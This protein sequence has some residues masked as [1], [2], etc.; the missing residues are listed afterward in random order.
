MCSDDK[1]TD[2]SDFQFR[3]KSGVFHEEKKEGKFCSDDYCS[4]EN[5]DEIDDMLASDED[6]DLSPYSENKISNSAEVK[7]DKTI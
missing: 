3:S 2:D 5:D 6:E 7:Q 1:E 4:R